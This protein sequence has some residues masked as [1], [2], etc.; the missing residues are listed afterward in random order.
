MQI[1]PTDI[2]M[3]KFNVNGEQHPLLKS[4]QKLKMLDIHRLDNILILADVMQDFL[5]TRNIRY[6]HRLISGIY[7]CCS[8][9]VWQI[10]NISV[11]GLTNISFA[12]FS[13]I[14]QKVSSVKWL[15]IYAFWMTQWQCSL[16]RGPWAWQCQCTGPLTRCSCTTSH[17]EKY[18]YISETWVISSASFV[19]V[20][21]HV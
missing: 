5:M 13:N 19:D 20:K 1:Y 18:R 17:N 10:K 6:Y 4:L 14:R 12:L 8:S 7:L 16:L 3:S 2:L 11:L 9:T 15:N 21:I